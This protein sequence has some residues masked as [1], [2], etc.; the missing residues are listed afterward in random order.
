MSPFP[1]F[2]CLAREKIIYLL[3]TVL[4]YLSLN[5]AKHAWSKVFDCLPPLAIPG[6][7]HNPSSSESEDSP[8]AHASEE[9]AG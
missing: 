9:E 8:G 2:R 4:H 3:K 6:V 5:K 1:T 7:L